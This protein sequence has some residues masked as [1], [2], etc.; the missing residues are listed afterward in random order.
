MKDAHNFPLSFARI[1][2]IKEALRDNP[3]ASSYIGLLNKFVYRYRFTRA[4]KDIEAPDIGERTRRGYT[5]GIR[6]LLAYSALEDIR[7]ARE[8]IPT[9]NSTKHEHHAKQ[10][11]KLA[12][13]LRKNKALLNL[14][15]N[16]P[17]IKNR[18]VRKNI[19]AFVSGESDDI[20]IVATCLRHAVA[21]GTFTT[22]GAGLGTV[23]AAKQIDELSNA[24]LTRAD[25]VAEV[26]I[27]ELEVQIAARCLK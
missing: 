22:G 14:L 12:N 21:H 6:L 25:E 3:K 19:N 26:C 9:L 5:A 24:V 2:R 18:S 4:V 11:H 1:K 15:V 17:N 27:T 16:D 7:K 10:N 13:E 20:L 23:V 8:A